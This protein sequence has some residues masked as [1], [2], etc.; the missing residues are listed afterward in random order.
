M[1][2]HQ[3]RHL[4]VLDGDELVGIVSMRDFPNYRIECLKTENEHLREYNQG[5]SRFL[6]KSP[7]AIYV[8]I[9][10]RIVFVNAKAMEI[11]GASDLSQLI[12]SSSLELFHPDF[13]NDIEI[14][15]ENLKAVGT[16]MPMAEVRRLPALGACRA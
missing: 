15:R 1:S 7:N 10:G 16:S 8:Q 6:E 2:I 12:G 11:F 3:I 14:R 13:R 9:G 5:L 4:P